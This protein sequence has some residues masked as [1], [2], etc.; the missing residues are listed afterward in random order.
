MGEAPVTRKL[1]FKMDMYECIRC[2]GFH[3]HWWAT[4]KVS[5]PSCAERQKRQK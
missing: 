5:P 4:S 2:R 3:A 1:R